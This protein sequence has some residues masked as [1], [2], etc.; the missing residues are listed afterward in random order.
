MRRHP[1]ATI[2]A[3]MEGELAAEH[4]PMQVVQAGEDRWLLRGHLARGNPLWRRL[5]AGSPVLVVFR[6]AEHYI[7][8]TWYA[9]KQEH[10]RVVPTWNYAAVHVSGTIRFVEDEDWLL[11][12]VQS[13]TGE[14]EQGRDPQWKVA[15]APADYRAMQLQAIVGFEIAVAEMRGK[16]KSSQNRSAADRA[17]VVD[18]LR[19]EGAIEP[20][21]EELVRAPKAD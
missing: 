16:F 14:H 5:P 3:T 12:L 7:S 20:D 2:I 10:G 15:D 4:L 18:G 8:P 13:L 9:S 19:A 17:G 1:L 11:G 6:G 21:I